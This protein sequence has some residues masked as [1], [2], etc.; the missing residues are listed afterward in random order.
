MKSDAS[1]HC[2]RCGDQTQRVASTNGTPEIGTIT[3]N[4]TCPRCGQQY[5]LQYVLS[6]VFATSPESEAQALLHLCA[7][8]GQLYLAQ[9]DEPHICRGTG[10][11]LPDAGSE[12][13]R[14]DT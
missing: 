6:A 3:V 9:Q 2:Y 12:V 11:S 13:E 10:P 7:Q 5:E 14:E 4:L 1:I 8:C